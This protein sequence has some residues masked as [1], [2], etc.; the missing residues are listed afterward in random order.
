[1]I[2]FDSLAQLH[3]EIAKLETL[4][5]SVEGRII[6]AMKISDNVEIDEP[7]PEVRIVGLH[8]GNEWISAEIPI[9][10]AHYL[11]DN[12]GSDPEVTYL[13]NNRE[14]WIIP[15]FNPDGRVHDTRYN[16]N[17]IDLNRDYGY[18]WE[19]EGGSS[20]P[21]SQPETKAM[22]LFS[23]KH[24]FVLSLSFH[25]YGEIV[26]YIWNYSPVEPPE[27]VII[28]EY[29]Y[30][31]ANFN[32]YEVTEGYDWYETR[33]DLN[34]YSM[35]IDSDIDWTI[36]LAEEF[37]PPASQIDTIWLENK[38]AILYII[39]KAGQGV[40]GIIKDSATGNCITNAHIIIEP[41]NNWVHF[42]NPN[43]GSF[44]ISLL[45]GDY[46]LKIKADGYAERN[47]SFTVYEDSLTWLGDIYLTRIQTLTPKINGYKFVWCN[48]DPY[49]CM[50]TYTL[51][52]FALG[53]P[54][55]HFLSIATSTYWGSMINYTGEVVIKLSKKIPTNNS[56]LV[57]YEGDDGHPNEKFKVYISDTLFNSWHFLGNG[58]GTDSFYLNGV[59]Y[60]SILYVR[61][62]NDY[63]LNNN[64]YPYGG[65]DLDAISV[66][67]GAANIKEKYKISSPSVS[68]KIK[69]PS[70]IKDK[71][72]RFSII[73]P[74]D[75]ATE[76]KIYSLQG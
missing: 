71:T 34:D 73:S 18:M 66:I 11:L 61:I 63:S 13:V 50:N 74:S 4:G 46:T 55:G 15:M 3:P 31:Y 7:E 1:M 41:Y 57:V 51:S 75:I 54:D 56:M 29:S 39:K 32:G 68:F 76:I 35:G 28:E 26:N 33:G 6:L 65:Y 24:Q 53:E 9:L 58:E 49:D 5:F 8:H 38:D 21:Y 36:E 30:G 67:I 27:S 2:D 52:P 14:I 59:P 72:L 19:G 48:T 37:V 60:D 16:A 44:F 40:G 22:Y 43:D 45:P 23:Q 70:I 12:Y 20:M 64:S 25:S 10:L 69:A 17:G 42:S 47:I 62:V